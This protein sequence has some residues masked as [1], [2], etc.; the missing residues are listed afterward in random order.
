[1]RAIIP[2]AGKGTRLLPHTSARQK[3]LLPVA[4]K[5]VLDHVLAP[6]IA[7]GIEKFSMIVGHLGSQIEKHMEGYEELDVAIVYQYRQ[8]GLGHAVLQGLTDDDDELLIVLADTIFDVNYADII[9]AGN[10][11]LAVVEVD[12]P[13]SFGIVETAGKRII[14]M[15]EKPEEP[16]SNLAIAGIYKLQSEGQ[17]KRALEK[18][19]DDHQLTN[20]EYQLTDALKLMLE[21]GANFRMESVNGWY[22]CGTVETLLATNRYL[23]QQQGDSF[24]HAEATTSNSTIRNSTV[25]EGCTINNSIIDSSILLPGAKLDKCNI[26]EEIVRDGADL[27]GYVSGR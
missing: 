23:L 17:L 19:I 1:M 10:N 4:G 24:I 16:P 3:A 15:V 21:A 27:T 5:A 13:K 7:G 8:L 11:V 26:R 12:N 2:V 18:I 14:D 6:L 20:G 9:A 22:D 25:M